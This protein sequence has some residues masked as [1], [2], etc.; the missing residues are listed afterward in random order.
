MEDLRSYSA[1]SLRHLLIKSA[2]GV[3]M[4]YRLYVP[5][6]YNAMQKY[7]LVIWLHGS[8]AIGTD[9]LKQITGYNDGGTRVWTTHWKDFPALVIAPQSYE[10]Y[11]SLQPSPLPAEEPLIMKTVAALE[12]EFGVDPNRIYLTG[13]SMGGFGVWAFLERRPDFYAAAIVLC[14]PASSGMISEAHTIARVPVWVF[15]GAKDDVVSAENARSM[16]ESL[17]KAGGRPLYTE[18]RD[19]GH[20][21]GPTAFAESGLLPWLF[22]QRRNLQQ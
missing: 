9:N 2:E 11:W 18:Y 7:P 15:Q 8:D 16:I 14:G 17:R 13:Q 1:N 6:N 5:P 4:P 12:E 20:L 19:L 22:A 10:R 3:R 21:I